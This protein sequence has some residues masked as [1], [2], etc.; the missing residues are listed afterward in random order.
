MTLVV[1]ANTGFGNSWIIAA[2]SYEA[3]TG[4]FTPDEGITVDD[5]YVSVVSQLV[6]AKYTYARQMIQQDYYQVLEDSGL[7]W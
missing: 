5:N 2:G 1:F 6:Q 7:E 4:I 3:C